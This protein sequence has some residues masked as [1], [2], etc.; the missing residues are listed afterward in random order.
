MA[1][2]SWLDQWI[3]ARL[4][5]W[6]HK[7]I[8]GVV[9]WCLVKLMLRAKL[10]LDHVRELFYG[11]HNPHLGLRKRFKRFL[12]DTLVGEYRAPAKQD[13]PP[14]S[15]QPRLFYMFL[16]NAGGLWLHH[17]SWPAKHGPPKAHVFL[18]YGYREHLYRYE[19]VADFFAERGFSFHAMD[20]Q[21]FGRS[22][23]I[24]GHVERFQHYVDDLI[25]FAKHIR[26]R[27]A[28]T[29][30][31]CFLLGHSMGGTVATNTARQMPGFWRGVMLLAPAI[32]LDPS[33]ASPI[34]LKIIHMVSDILPKLPI[35]SRGDTTMNCRNTLAL[36]QE[37]NDPLA[38]HEPARARWGS[39]CLKAMAEIEA[40]AES[41]NFSFIIYHGSNDVVIKIEGSERFYKESSSQDKELKVYPDVYHD[42]VNDH[43][44]ADVL[45]HMVGWVEARL[46]C[47]PR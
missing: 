35:Q 30:E 37:G 44:G 19:P 16:E 33:N 18:S 1:S 9:V 46:G 11:G 8:F 25:L 22:E 32:V 47:K 23:G 4:P 40:N 7:Y 38:F 45:M 21:G 27:E 15:S 41:I 6:T 26:D 29:D 3:L 17:R 20:H 34:V 2:S 31:P 5:Q 24:R 28:I 42:M 43:Q 12:Q 39:E 10:D 13:R 14:P 36:Q